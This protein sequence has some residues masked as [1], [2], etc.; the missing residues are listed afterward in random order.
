MHERHDEPVHEVP[1]QGEDR[2]QD[3]RAEHDVAQPPRRTHLPE[4]AGGDGKREESDNG[5]D[6]RSNEPGWPGGHRLLEGT[7]TQIDREGNG[8]G[9]ALGDEEK[10]AGERKRIDEAAQHALRMMP[11]ASV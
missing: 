10:T 7:A 1:R 5:S 6:H 4:D 8:D 9:D 3:Q 2:H 11:T